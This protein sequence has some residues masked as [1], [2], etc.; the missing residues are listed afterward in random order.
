M[1]FSSE[2]KKFALL[3]PLNDLKWLENSSIGI[4]GGIL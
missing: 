3:N 2:Y 1:P 4:D